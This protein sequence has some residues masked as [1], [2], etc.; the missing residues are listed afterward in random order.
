MLSFNLSPMWVGVFDSWKKASVLHDFHTTTRVSNQFLVPASCFNRLVTDG[1]DTY[2]N[3]GSKSRGR[4]AHQLQWRWSAAISLL[5]NCHLNAGISSLSGL[6]FLILKIWKPTFQGGSKLPILLLNTL[7]ILA[8]P[9]P[10]L[11]HLSKCKENRR[12]FIERERSVSLSVVTNRR[13]LT[14]RSLKLS[15]NST[16]KRGHA[17]RRLLQKA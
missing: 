4:W 14:I 12:L 8:E 2:V 10:D 1:Y 13:I 16:Q 17:V 9:P 6:F 11:R 15:A 3:Q 5:T 7:D